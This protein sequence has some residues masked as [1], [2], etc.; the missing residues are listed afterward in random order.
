MKKFYTV[1]AVAAIAV[2]VA[3]CNPKPAE[4]GKNIPECKNGDACDHTKGS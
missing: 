3:A 4:P 2:A 1:L